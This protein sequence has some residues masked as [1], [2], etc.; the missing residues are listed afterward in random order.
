MDAV[1]L[2][3]RTPGLICVLLPSSA[4]DVGA[5]ER[6]AGLPAG[7]LPDE[8]AVPDVAAVQAQAELLPAVLVV[9][10]PLVQDVAVPPVR[11]LAEPVAPDAAAE[12]QAELLAAAALVDVPREQDEVELSVLVPDEPAGLVAAEQDA[13]PDEPAAPDVPPVPDDSLAL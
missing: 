2:F 12:V 11:V 6:Q 13:F 4:Q 7:A 8:P 1:V 3:Y 5:A 10:A 9:D